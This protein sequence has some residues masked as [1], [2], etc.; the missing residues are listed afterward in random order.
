[1]ALF[2]LYTDKLV[3]CCQEF[4]GYIVRIPIQWLCL[5]MPVASSGY[6]T[7]ASMLHQGCI[8]AASMLLESCVHLYSTVVLW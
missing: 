4:G 3:S 6:F 5:D 7:I 1:M 2:V 8:S